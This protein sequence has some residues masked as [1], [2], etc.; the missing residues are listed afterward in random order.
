MSGD[1]VIAACVVDTSVITA[2]GLR[3]HGFEQYETLLENATEIWMSAPTR[4]ELG[5]VSMNRGFNSQASEIVT[6]YDIRI[7]PFD[8]PLVTIALQAFERFGKGRHKAALNFGDCCS[9]ALAV[10][11]QLPLLF[12]GD[13]FVQTDVKNALFQLNS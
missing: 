5:I 10:S 1:S 12:K 6:A 8:E 11:R 2:I 7:A 13:D 9:Y 4:L 3:E